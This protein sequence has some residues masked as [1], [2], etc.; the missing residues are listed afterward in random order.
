[1]IPKLPLLLLLCVFAI[2]L[3]DGRN[4]ERHEAVAR[5]HLEGP[6][7]WQTEGA[8]GTW[9]VRWPDWP[10]A[11]GQPYLHV[12]GLPCHEHG[13]P[14]PVELFLRVE[15]RDVVTTGKDC[16][17]DASGW[18]EAG[19]GWDFDTVATLN[20]GRPCSV[21]YEVRRDDP[22]DSPAAFLR[23]DGTDDGLIEEGNSVGRFMRDVA[24]LLISLPLII[25]F[26]VSWRR[27][28]K[29]RRAPASHPT[30]IEGA[31]S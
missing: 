3:W 20:P 29:A 9:N 26:G 25:W 4:D 28:R 16:P 17:M 21:E 13:K 15:P 12:R 24:A 18:F 1:V 27:R 23:I 19:N 30:A 5:L 31:P 10:A 22:R 8:H 6:S 14:A 2:W 7:F 11:K